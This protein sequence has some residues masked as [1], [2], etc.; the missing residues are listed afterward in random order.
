MDIVEQPLSVVTERF[1]RLGFNAHTGTKVK[2]KLLESGLI[3]Q[4][5][6][7]A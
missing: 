1:R 7:R 6:Q 3:E 2:W 5:N 4:E